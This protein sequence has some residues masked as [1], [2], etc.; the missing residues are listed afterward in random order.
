MISEQERGN[1]TPRQVPPPT[2]GLT[3]EMG[4]KLADLAL[5]S[6]GHADLSVALGEARQMLAALVERHPEFQ[7]ASSELLAK[8]DQLQRP[9]ALLGTEVMTYSHLYEDANVGTP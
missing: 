3:P 4:A 7:G 1:M 8:L 5:M 2:E 9:L 6:E